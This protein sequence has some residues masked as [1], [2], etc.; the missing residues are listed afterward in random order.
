MFGQVRVGDCQSRTKLGSK[1]ITFRVLATQRRTGA[2]ILLPAGPMVE[3]LA[4]GAYD[5]SQGV[6]L[7]IFLNGAGAY[8]TAKAQPIRLGN[9]VSCYPD[10]LVFTH[11]LVSHIGVRVRSFAR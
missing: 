11:R 1:R 7:D 6:V 5:R 10:S 3:R 8:R 4:I 9:V 2:A